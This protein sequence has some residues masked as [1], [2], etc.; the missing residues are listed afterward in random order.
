MVITGVRAKMPEEQISQEEQIIIGGHL[1]KDKS[2]DDVRIG[3]Y[4]TVPVVLEL[5]ERRKNKM[6]LGTAEGTLI[7]N[8]LLDTQKAM[9]EEAR[10]TTVVL[11]QIAVDMK[12]I[13][14]RME[15][16]AGIQAT[17]QAF[18]DRMLK[19]EM[20]VAAQKIEFARQLEVQN[21]EA[22]RRQ[23]FILQIIGAIT[24]FVGI[25]LSYALPHIKW[26]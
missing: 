4:H 3:D 24:T 22:A 15:P 6:P 23:R 25:M 7:V 19:L 8:Q 21:V 11:Q 16:I 10:A 1:P 13:K 26:K 9:Q 20:E 12:E 17:N 18:S 14:V 5:G 2:E